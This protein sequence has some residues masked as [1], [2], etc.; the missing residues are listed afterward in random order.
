VLGSA[1]RALNLVGRRACGLRRPPALLIAAGAAL[2]SLTAGALNVSVISAGA[3][4][5]QPI[6]GMAGTPSGGGFWLV[7]GDGGVFPSGDAGGYGSTGNSRLNQ[8]IVGMAATNDGGGYWLVAG[9]GG[10]FPF[11]NAGGFGS[12]GSVRLNQPIVGMAATPSGHG[13][14]LVA[15][16]GGIFPFGDAGGYGS[17][18]AQRLNQPIVGMN[19]TPSGHGYWLVASDGGIFPFGDAGGY[20]S[21][22][23]IRLN[24]PIVGMASTPSGRGYWLVARDGGIFPFGDA[25]GFGSA[26]AVPL[27][28]PVIGLARTARGQGYWL[29]TADAHV[30]DFGD[31]KGGNATVPTAPQATVPLPPVLAPCSGA[32]MLSGQADID[33]A[34]AGTSF[35]IVGTHNWSLT[36]KSGDSFGGPAVLDGAG[37][38]QTAFSGS[39]TNVTLTSLTIQHYVAPMQR[40]AIQPNL[41]SGGWTLRALDIGYNAY[42]GLNGSDGMQILGG[43]IHDNGQEGIGTDLAN[44]MVLDG[45]E[46]DHNNTARVDCGFEAGGIKLVGNND[47]IRNSRIHDNYC[48]GIWAD[49]NAYGTTVTGNQVYDNEAEG[50]FIEISNHTS[51]T[52]NSVWGNGFKTNPGG[53]CS[54][55]WGGGITF[56][57]SS[58]GDV[59]GNTVSGNCNG[60]TGTQQNRPEGNP[61]LLQNLNVHNNSVSG[62]GK[63]GTAQ[64]TGAN[65][66]TR[67]IQFTSDNFTGGQ[68][69]CGVSC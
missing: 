13:Y 51:V 48:K 39:A 18:G 16:D 3:S 33:A 28:N 54:W 26:G 59:S 45:V 57:S 4:L 1:F 66:A 10:I 19:A 43:R 32:P 8:P 47:V 31:A 20:G 53:G 35:C 67:N 61:G 60:I 25:G 23:N 24:Q 11:G 34:P 36:P 52:A 56:A 21:T 58:D 22:G 5:N 62:A 64:D 69:Y 42:A 55:L 29:T 6:V 44:W 50:I 40:G 7:A 9:D 2:A 46:I 17:T 49:I 63:S 65:L 41:R 68:Q 38:L 14:W 15:R 37:S 30:Y 12:T 27:G